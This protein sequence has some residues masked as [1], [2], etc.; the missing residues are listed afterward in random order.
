MAITDRSIVMPEF[1]YDTAF[2]RNLG[3][4]SRD[5]QARL[6]QSIVAIA[7][8]GGVGGD[9]L[10]SLV[11]AGVGGFHLDL[12][13]KK[14][15]SFIAACKLCAALVTTRAQTALI[16]PAEVNLVPWYT[17]VDLRLNRFH[18][19]RLWFGNRNPLQRLKAYVAGSRLARSK[20]I[21][22]GV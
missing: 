7:G 2:G 12:V 18:H 1:S 4:V 11:R 15:P 5:E 3:I 19:R 10:I 8:M 6:R 21:E 20:Q 13:E 17:Y 9:Y 22:A 14:D 16:H